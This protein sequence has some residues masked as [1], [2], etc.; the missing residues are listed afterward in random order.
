MAVLGP[1]IVTLAACTALALLL[2]R[3]L[4]YGRIA[5]GLAAALG[6]VWV[7]SWWLPDRSLGRGGVPV[8]VAAVAALLVQ[9]H[10]YSYLTLP[11][12]ILLAAAPLA[13]W[14]GFIGP[15]R[16][17]APWQSAILAAVLALVPA[18]I[19]VGLA[20][21]SSPGEYE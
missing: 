12:G 16:R 7:V 13:A 19:A 11:A 14:P 8:V 4:V 21:A 15:A 3:C 17:L 10:I 6:A 20:H 1:T 9:G 2:S 5:G 18:G